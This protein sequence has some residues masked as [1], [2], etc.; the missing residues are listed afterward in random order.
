MKKITLSIICLVSVFIIACHDAKK[1]ENI[2]TGKTEFEEVLTQQDSDEVAKL[3]DAY[4]NLVI[5]GKYYDAA[6][7]LYRTDDDHPKNEPIPLETEELEQTVK[8]LEMMPAQNY[9]IQYMKFSEEHL[10]EV[11]CDVII[12]EAQGNIPEIKTKMTFMPIRYLGYWVLT[13]PNFETGRRTIVKGD[14]RDSIRQAYENL[15][16]EK[17]VAKGEAE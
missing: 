5:D 13:V 1:P 4:F 6:A 11:M 8:I 15:E 3:I 2:N 10:N 17:K 7:M 14:E 16:Y 9:R 12:A